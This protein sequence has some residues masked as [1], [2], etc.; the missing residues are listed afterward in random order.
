MKPLVL[1]EMTCSLNVAVKKEYLLNSRG[2]HC[3]KAKLFKDAKLG[4]KHISHPGLSG[5]VYL[6]GFQTKLWFTDHWWYL[7]SP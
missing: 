4:R 5:L 1:Q 6:S 2:S 3:R 7:S